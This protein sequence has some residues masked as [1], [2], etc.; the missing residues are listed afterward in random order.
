MFITYD[1]SKLEKSSVLVSLLCTW[2]ERRLLKQKKE[3][4]APF[5]KEML[6]GP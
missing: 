1:Y 6:Y 2:T 5:M 3:T 4:L